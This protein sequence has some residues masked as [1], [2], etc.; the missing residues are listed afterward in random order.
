MRMLEKLRLQMVAWWHLS[1]EFGL[2]GDETLSPTPPPPPKQQCVGCVCP[3]KFCV[4]SSD[5]FR[6]ASEA[7][8]AHSF[9]RFA[10]DHARQLSNP[11]NQH[12]FMIIGS[13]V[14][15]FL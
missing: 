11:Q 14:L 1:G 8:P 15:G 7:I 2:Q 13:I 5:G 4:A 6:M 12:L 10:L 3:F 9:E